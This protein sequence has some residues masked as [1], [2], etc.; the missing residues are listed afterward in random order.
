M[1]VLFALQ[2]HFISDCCSFVVEYIFFFSSY[3]EFTIHRELSID[4]ITLIYLFTTIFFLFL[5]VLFLTLF[6]K[7]FHCSLQLVKAKKIDDLLLCTTNFNE[8]FRI[9]GYLFFFSFWNVTNRMDVVFVQIS[10]DTRIN[11]NEI[12]K[13]IANVCVCVWPNVSTMQIYKCEIFL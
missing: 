2:F 6:W 1:C 12:H 11:H 13:I 7:L 8:I 5:F 4:L 3:F 9:F 10:N